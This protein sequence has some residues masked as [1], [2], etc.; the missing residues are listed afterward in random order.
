VPNGLSPKPPRRQTSRLACGKPSAWVPSLG[1]LLGRKSD[2]D[3][4]TQTLWLGLQRLDNI[5]AMW[6][7]PAHPAHSPLVFSPRH[8]RLA[9]PEGRGR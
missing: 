7:I 3:P 8:E 5:N 1:G 2:V 9:P 6:R 4:G